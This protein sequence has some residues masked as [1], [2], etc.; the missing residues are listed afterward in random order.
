VSYV[1]KNHVAGQSVT[2]SGITT[3]TADF[4]GVDIIVAMATWGG[5]TPTISDSQGNTYTALT[6]HS[7][8]GLFYCSSPTIS[9]SMTFSVSG[10]T[11]NAAIAVAGF[12]A[13]LSS[14]LDVQNGN[15]SSTS[16]SL[17]TGSITPSVANELVITGYGSADWTA[18]VTCSL[19]TITDALGNTTHGEAV[20]LAY[21]IQTTATAEN[22]TWTATSGIH[23]GIAIASF[24]AV[25]P[26]NYNKTLTGSTTKAGALGRRISRKLTASAAKAAALFRRVGKA[27]TASTAKAGAIARGRVYLRTLTGST[28]KAGKVLHAAAKTFTASTAKGGSLNR[29]IG[30][31]VTASGA[32]NAVLKRSVRKT[33]TAHMTKQADIIRRVGKLLP[34]TIL[35]AGA[36]TRHFHKT[37][38]AFATR[39]AALITQSSKRSVLLTAQIVRGGSLSIAG[40]WKKLTTT[41]AIWTKK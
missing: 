12:S 8:R 25:A 26:T 23:S 6:L 24:K 39:N 9:S 20:G 38:S 34:A 31:I 4:T 22:A 7:T 11:N 21:L 15:T 35:K 41:A 40:V 28:A 30:K 33:V 29:H 2:G 1:F 18:P 17:A 37:L 14:V 36:L 32:R 19:G 16:T 13:G 27:F 3:V 10:T 5:S